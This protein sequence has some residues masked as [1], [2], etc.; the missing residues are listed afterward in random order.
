MPKNKQEVFI[1]QSGYGR[2][3]GEFYAYDYQSFDGEGVTGDLSSYGSQSLFGIEVVQA[4]DNNTT[5]VVRDCKGTYTMESSYNNSSNTVPITVRQ[6][7]NEKY[8]CIAEE[9][10]PYNKT[11]VSFAFGGYMPYKYN[12]KVPN[13]VQYIQFE[14][15]Q[16]WECYTAVLYGLEV[17]DTEEDRIITIPYDVMNGDTI[18]ESGEMRIVQEAQFGVSQ[19]TITVPVE[20]GEYYIEISAFEDWTIETSGAFFTVDPMSGSGDGGFLIKVSEN[21]SVDM[22]EGIIYVKSGG[23]VVEIRVIQEA[24]D[25]SLYFG[26]HYI[27]VRRAGELVRLMLY[28]NIK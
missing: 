10:I 25:P 17:N 22:R 7:G 5:G 16:N 2:I 23:E 9:R 6:V 20:G 13:Y 14:D 12:I 11:C 21:E 4:K 18:V 27:P 15:P 3:R 26:K 24:V 1:T 28:T 19:D 8:T